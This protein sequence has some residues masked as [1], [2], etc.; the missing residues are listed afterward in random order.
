MSISCF[1][2]STSDAV[3]RHLGFKPVTATCLESAVKYIFEYLSYDFF[4]KREALKR[5]SFIRYEI[6]AMLTNFVGLAK[7]SMGSKS[8]D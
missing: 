5:S 8:M 2:L 4:K 1:R 6:S 3:K 7:V